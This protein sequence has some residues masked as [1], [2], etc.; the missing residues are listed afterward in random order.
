MTAGPT[1]ISPAL[2]MPIVATPMAMPSGRPA[3]PENA[4]PP[5]DRSSKHVELESHTDRRRD[6]AEPTGDQHG[7][8]PI[9]NP[10]AA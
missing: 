4:T 9:R 10:L 8:S 5:E 3:P 6:A 7:T 2:R 1:K